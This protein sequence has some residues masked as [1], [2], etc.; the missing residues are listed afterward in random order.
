MSHASHARLAT[1]LGSLSLFAA[2]CAAAAFSHSVHAGLAECTKARKSASEQ[3]N[4]HMNEAIAASQI[5]GDQALKACQAKGSPIRECAREMQNSV[6][7]N[8]SSLE[9]AIKTCNIAE[10]TCKQKCTGGSNPQEIAQIKK[11]LKSCG[12]EMKALKEQAKKGQKQAGEA[13]KGA[14]Q[15]EQAA[16]GNNSENSSGNSA[17]PMIPPMMQ[18]QGGDEAS[19]PPATPPPAPPITPMANGSPAPAEGTAPEKGVG[20]F[21]TE[22]SNSKS[23][24]MEACVKELAAKSDKFCD[25][26]KYPDRKDSCPSCR[27]RQGLSVHADADPALCG[28]DPMYSVPGAVASAMQAQSVTAPIAAGGG[29]AG[30]GGVHKGGGGEAA[31]DGPAPTDNAGH[32][33]GQSM[34]SLGVDGSGGYSGYGGGDSGGF[35]GGSNGFPM[36]MGAGGP[37]RATASDSFELSASV[38]DIGRN[39]LTP[40]VFSIHDEVFRNRCK[41][42]RFLHPCGG[43]AK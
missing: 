29:A 5:Q 21:S 43:R 38:T 1:P 26:P 37:G 4:K 6:G 9:G 25:D 28:T 27:K 17:M 22:C 23:M 32:R 39:S 36:T 16:A 24:N 30:G 14:A 8:N 20:G 40:N 3:C 10:D 18:P 33:E 13:G 2:I 42:G 7:F 41:A 12:D 19:T 31:L 11:E 15:T 34:G 35:E